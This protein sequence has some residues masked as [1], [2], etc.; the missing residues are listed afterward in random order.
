MSAIATSSSK[1]AVEVTNDLYA[2]VPQYLALAEDMGRKA[3]E[4]FR[5]LRSI[6]STRRNELLLA[7]AEELQIPHHQESIL[8]ANALDI[9]AA[10][11]QALQASL[12]DR[13][14]LNKQRLNGMIRALQ[15][16][17]SL[18]DPLGEVL[19]GKYL[20]NGIELLQKRVPLGVL[21]TIYEARPNVTLDVAALCLKS[22]NCSILRG[23]REAWHTNQALFFILQKVLG[24]SNFP[25]ATVQFVEETDRA[26]MLTLLQQEQ[27]IDLVVP[28]GGEALI[29]FI[30]ENSRIPVVKHDKGV[31]NMYIDRSADLEQAVALA[32]N[33][34]LQRPSVCNAI[35]NILIHKDFNDITSLLTQ[36]AKAGVR[37]HGCT[38]SQ[39]YCE[40]VELI[41]AREYDKEYSREYLDEQLSVKIVEN[42]EEAIDFIYR[43]GSGHS[44]AI[45]AH[46][47]ECIRYFQEQV[48]TAAV[49]VN[50]STR[51]HDGGQMGFGAE[52][53]IST[54][55]LHVRGPMAL[56]DLT[57]TTFF[58]T[59]SGQIR[60]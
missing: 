6:D 25:T 13:I 30:S 7:L 57:T 60:S 2:R 24:E 41:P 14:K 8:K 20:P 54:G 21:F 16:I 34:K 45:V 33:S 23:G 37:L 36:L 46:D 56:K 39:S 43:Y 5:G 1:K 50:C 55:R 28:R 42:M 26:F 18:P 15:E 9:S 44:E 40:T 53:G 59:G 51:F 58:M 17:A 3:R 48:D 38:R 4:A 31:C 49:F 10:Q 19:Q 12:I 52:V 11:E 35:E 47:S 32:I 29:R 27:W 22:G